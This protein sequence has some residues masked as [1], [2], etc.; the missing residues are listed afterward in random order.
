MELVV[1]KG[2]FLQNSD[3]D[4]GEVLEVLDGVEA[5]GVGVVVVRDNSESQVDQGSYI[6][7]H[8]SCFATSATNFDSNE[9]M[10]QMQAKI[11]ALEAQV[12]QVDL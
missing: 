1:T 6:I 11:V 9:K 5:E 4:L 2:G 10:K 3:D 8:D 7:H 12:A